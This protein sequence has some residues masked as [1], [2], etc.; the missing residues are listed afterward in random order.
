MSAIDSDLE[1]RILF[2]DNHLLAVNKKAGEIVQG[3]KTGDEALNERI[4]KYLKRKYNKPGD[5]F[6]GIVHR[7]DRP[8]SGVVVFAKTSKGASRL[9][10]QFREKEIRKTYLAIT[11]VKPPQNSGTLTHYLKK[12]QKNNKSSAAKIPS[13]GRKQAVLDYTLIKTSDRYYLLEIKPVTGRHHQIRVQ[14]SAEGMPIKGDLKYGFDRSNKDGSIS[15]HAREIQF[16]HPTLKNT[17]TLTAP[18]PEDTLWQY[19]ENA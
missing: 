9:S 3:D 6:L 18:A 16:S 13:P 2:E 1:K 8:T 12:N 14:L 7:L 10:K 15:L 19:F 5:A 11:A 17:V 4:K